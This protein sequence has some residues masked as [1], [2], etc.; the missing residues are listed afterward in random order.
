MLKFMHG[1]KGQALEII[2][3]LLCLFVSYFCLKTK[4]MCTLLRWCQKHI[5]LE[6]GG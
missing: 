2:T 1:S 6:V 4:Q 5:S 3:I